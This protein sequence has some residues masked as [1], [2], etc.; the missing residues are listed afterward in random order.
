[1]CVPACMFVPQN[2]CC[3]V[4]HSVGF[5]CRIVL[6]GYKKPLDK[7]DLWSL[8]PCDQTKSVVPIFEHEWNKEMKKFCRSVLACSS[9]VKPNSFRNII[10]EFLNKVDL[11]HKIVKEYCFSF[12]NIV[13][14]QNSRYVLPWYSGFYTKMSVFVG[15]MGTGM[16]FCVCI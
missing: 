3:N 12:R 5:F 8:N 9:V 2:A 7:R 11:L 6:K 14:F 16:F 15:C 4:I 1:M 13:H 10:S